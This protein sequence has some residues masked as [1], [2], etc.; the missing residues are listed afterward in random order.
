MSDNPEI[1]ESESKHESAEIMN[2][3]Q[4]RTVMAEIAEHS[5]S[6]EISAINQAVQ[7]TREPGEGGLRALETAID[8]MAAIEMKDTPRLEK[9]YEELI[10]E[11]ATRSLEVELMHNAD[12]SLAPSSQP[13]SSSDRLIQARQALEAIVT[14]DTRPS[15]ASEALAPGQHQLADIQRNFAPTATEA[16][17]FKTGFTPEAQLTMARELLD[18]ATSRLKNIPDGQMVPD[19][20]HSVLGD[21]PR[22][23]QEILGFSGGRVTTTN[24]ALGIPFTEVARIAGIELPDDLRAKLQTN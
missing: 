10:K 5:G 7:S 3:E 12:Q 6:R 9:V 8:L 20:V 16:G 2:I 19:T 4:A 14:S 22:F 21:N 11:R 15:A 24:E 13:E 18:L 1:L 17:S 23:A